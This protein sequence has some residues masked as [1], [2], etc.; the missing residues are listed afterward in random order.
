M[1]RDA[2]EHPELGRVVPELNQPSIRERIVSPYRLVYLVEG[3]RVVVLGI[4][5]G[6]RLMPS[7]FD[8]E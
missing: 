2:A 4:V 7:R 5:H 6:R 1:V 8:V 3:G